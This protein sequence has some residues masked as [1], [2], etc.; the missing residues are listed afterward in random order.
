VM[1]QVML[2]TEVPAYSSRALPDDPDAWKFDNRP[3][4]KDC[5]SLAFPIARMVDLDCPPAD[6]AHRLAPT[7]F[8]GRGWDYYRLYH[9]TCSNFRFCKV[10]HTKFHYPLVKQPETTIIYE[11]KSRP[12]PDYFI[13]LAGK[14]ANRILKSLCF[15]RSCRMRVIY[16][17]KLLFRAMVLRMLE[18]LSAPPSREIKGANIGYTQGCRRTEAG[19]SPA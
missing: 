8:E 12:R 18:G 13:V 5:R 3:T 4:A 16:T 6:G 10:C 9:P 1:V 14:V 15:I 7:R 17:R 19:E 2:N 11:K